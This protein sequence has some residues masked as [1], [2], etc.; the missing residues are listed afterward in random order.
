MFFPEKVSAFFWSVF[1][2]IPEKARKTPETVRKKA[3]NF[4]RKKRNILSFKVLHFMCSISPVFGVRHF[5][6]I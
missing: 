6:I 1:G 5:V 2:M 4:S 3:E